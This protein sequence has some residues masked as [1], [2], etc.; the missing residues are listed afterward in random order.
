[1]SG[2]GGA[3]R[4]LLLV[5]APFLVRSSSSAPQSDG[6]HSVINIGALLP[7]TGDECL[8]G[9]HYRR[10]VDA[11]ARYVNN[12][13]WMQGRTLN[14][15]VYDTKSTVYGAWDAASIAAKESWGNSVLV[16]P[17]FSGPAKQASVVAEHETMPM[18]LFDATSPH[19]S[20]LPLMMRTCASNWMRS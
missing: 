18:V 10:A 13:P 5:A 8:L 20:N 12:R 2:G 3:L 15:T 7:E 19:L 14:L 11:A 17:S 9:V 16:G 6:G 4:L 1:M